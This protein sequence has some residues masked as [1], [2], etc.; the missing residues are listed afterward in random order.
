MKSIAAKSL[1]L[2]LSVLINLSLLASAWAANH[3]ILL[4]LLGNQLTLINSQ[5]MGAG[6][7]VSDRNLEAV[8]PSKDSSLDDMVLFETNEAILRQQPDAD[9]MAWHSTSP[10]LYALQQQ[11]AKGTP[12]DTAQLAD[13]FKAG[14]DAGQQ[15][16]LILITAL[17]AELQLKIF[18]SAVGQARAAGLGFYIDKYT[19]MAVLET[20]ERA[21]GFLGTFANFNVSLID[22]DSKTLLA[23]HPAAKGWA[24]PAVLAKDLE[25]WHA[26]T[27]EQKSGLLQKLVRD[28][29]K[30]TIPELLA[31]PHS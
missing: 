14:F 28:G 8:L 15:P 2:V 13:L 5:P 24:T 19:P 12:I 20:N 16:R 21:I 11:W 9:V 18:H 10:K 25:P 26:L 3:Y 27:P 31:A 29:I 22:L 1:L 4:S 7:R 6:S 17:E 30:D 23:S